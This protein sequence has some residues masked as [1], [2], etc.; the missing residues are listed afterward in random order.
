MWIA[1]TLRQINNALNDQESSV[2]AA[3]EAKKNDGRDEPRTIVVVPKDEKENTAA[4]DK[5]KSSTTERVMAVATSIGA[6]AAIAAAIGAI[7]YANIAAKQLRDMQAT[8][9]E[10][11]AQTKVAGIAAGASSSEAKTA[12]AALKE[13]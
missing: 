9:R 11:R 10:I 3:A 7:V 12:S 2:D 5:A 13:S 6:A 1:E 8:Y 4:S